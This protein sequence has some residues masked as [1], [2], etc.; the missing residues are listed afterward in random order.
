MVNF[1]A[2]DN[3]DER[4][5]DSIRKQGSTK[6]ILNEIEKW[7]MSERLVII[8]MAVEAAGRKSIVTDNKKG[9]VVAYGSSLSS[10]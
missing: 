4:S 3:F 5:G 10:K 2:F 7:P 9:E 6:I 8:K 1:V